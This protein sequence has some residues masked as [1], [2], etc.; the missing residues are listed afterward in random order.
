[1]AGSQPWI[2]PH[3]NRIAVRFILIVEK[4]SFIIR[5]LI[6]FQEG[7]VFVLERFRL[8]VK[9]LIFDVIDCFVD[10]RRTY[11]ECTITVLSGEFGIER[12]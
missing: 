10:K 11:G 3:G 12:R 4:V 8:M 5:K 1:M 7:F 6:G 2:L 9:V